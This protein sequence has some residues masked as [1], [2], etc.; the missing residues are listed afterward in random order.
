MRMQFKQ[1]LS[2]GHKHKNTYI[3]KNK[4]NQ[5][6][7]CFNDLVNLGNISSYFLSDNNL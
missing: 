1:I 6:K 2:M 5:G 3:N 7:F 4:K